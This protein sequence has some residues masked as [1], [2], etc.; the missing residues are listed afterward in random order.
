MANIP[1]SFANIDDQKERRAIID[2]LKNLSLEDLIQVETFNLKAGLAGRKVQKLT[3]T[4]AAL[5]VITQEDIRR[6]GITHLAEALRMVPGLQVARI[7]A[8]EWAISARGLNETNASKLLVMIDGRT[9]YSPLRSDVIWNL[10]DLLIEDVERIEIVRGPGASLWGANAVNGIIN[11]ITKSTKDTQGNLASFHLGK[12]EEKSIISLRHGGSLTNNGHYRIYGKF[13]QHDN[14]KNSQGQE[15]P[16]EWEMK[17][18]GFRIDWDSSQDDTLTLQGDIF[19]GFIQNTNTFFTPVIQTITNQHEKKGLNLLA[20]WQ[21][22]LTHGEMILQSYYDVSQQNRGLFDYFRGI[23]DLDFQHRWQR[24]EQH[25][26]IWGL[27]FRYIHDD[28]DGSSNTTYTPPKRQDRL[29]SAFIQNEFKIPLNSSLEEDKT[30]L[31][32]IVGSKFE[33]NDY[34]GFEFQP[35]ARLLWNLNDRHNIWAAISRAVRT[36]SRSESDIRLNV[37]SP[38]FQILIQGNPDLQSETLLSYELGYRFNL[39]NQFLLDTS[40]FYNEYDKLRTLEQV[41]FRPFPPPSLLALQVDNQMYG[42]IYG[43][44]L[45]THWQVK[46][47]WKLITTYSYLDTQLHL[48]T[49]SLDGNNSESIENNSPHHQANIRSLLTLAHEVEFDTALYYVDNLSNQNVAHYTRFDVRL[50]WQP[51]DNLTLS[52]GARNLLDKQHNEF[53]GEERTETNSEVP[54][55]FY[56]QLKYQFE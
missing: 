3:E 37:P 36:P 24:N 54:R 8:H 51:G 18:A 38:Q 14:F 56:L 6:A 26:W 52:L 27:G 4:A 45:A 9:V 30:E 22:N 46:D 55:T 11:I 32:L 25:E 28:I 1:I 39:T 31:R 20:R 44:E 41:D 15:Q 5:F 49:T 29:F 42:E 53:S 23:Y 33:H 17:W 16:D 10:Q 40:L 13:Y 47:N 7:N 19:D 34:S 48:Q 2:Q 43:L 12:G 35:T 50:G 21:K